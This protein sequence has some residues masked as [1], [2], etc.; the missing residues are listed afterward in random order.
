M[1][2]SPDRGVNR[3]RPP[4]RTAG[5]RCCRS[6]PAPL[7]TPQ[8]ELLRVR[9]SPRPASSR[10]SINSASHCSGS[11]STRGDFFPP[12]TR[13]GRLR[14]Y[15]IAVH[16]GHRQRQRFEFRRDLQLVEGAFPLADDAEQLEQK[17]AKLGSDGRAG[18]LPAGVQGRRG[19][20]R[21]SGPA[22]P[23]LKEPWLNPPSIRL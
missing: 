16:L 8:T 20:R 23:L 3:R 11:P 18:R 15:R 13:R 14:T 5:R 19:D 7:R 17:D 12:K 9:G 22:R 6:T 21:L 4:I 2:P 1:A 10:D